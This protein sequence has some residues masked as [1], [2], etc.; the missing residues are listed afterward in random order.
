MTNRIIEIQSRLQEKYGV[1]A[2]PGKER[3]PGGRSMSNGSFDIRYEVPLVPQQ[4]GMSCWAAGAAM[5]VAWR[6]GYSVDPQQIAM[7]TGEWASY[8]D[9]LH[10][11]NASI[12]NVW[13]LA[14]EPQQSYSVTAFGKLLE[15]YGP[16]WVG[17]AAP[18]PHI[19]VVT[20]IYGDSTPDGTYVLVNDPWQK[21]MSTFSL[22]NVGAQY[23]ETYREF[24]L[25]TEGLASKEGAAF[26]RAIY[27]AHSIARRGPRNQSRRLSAEPLGRNQR[28]PF[29]LVTSLR[30]RSFALP[31]SYDAP[32]A[33]PAVQ[34]PSP[35]TSWAAAAAMLVSYKE[36]RT[37][38]AE[39][40][41][42]RAGGRY[43]LML[44][45]D[46][47]MPRSEMGTFL[48]A[49]GLASEPVT[50][51]T[52]EQLHSMLRRFG[53]VWLTP[54]YELA[55][56]PD[57]RIV[58]G[59]HGD[60]TATGTT[61]T[62]RDPHT[63]A[64]MKVK[65]DALL[66]LY[67]HF[68][69]A[70][71]PSRLLAVYWFPDTL[72]EVTPADGATATH[73]QVQQQSQWSRAQNPIA[74]ADAIQM[75]LGAVSV[76]QAQVA[77]SQGAFTLT[78][79]KAQR[80]L[81]TEAR[82]SMPGS[83]VNKQNYRQRLLFLGA[84]GVNLA[85]AQVFIE[86]EGNPYGEI[87]TPIIRRDLSSSTE[88]SRSSAQITI[89]KVDR[90]PLPN[91]DPRTWPVVY[92]YEGTYDPFGNGYFEFSGEFE[93]NAFGSLRF[94]RHEV[95]SRSLLDFAIRGVPEQYV[96]KGNDVIMPIPAIPQE[97]LDYLR[98]KLP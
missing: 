22:P 28:Q 52:V 34:Q 58:T 55:F 79:D 24:V 65:F 71:L 45:N 56:S 64:E 47:T 23:T 92:S 82:A 32:R 14:P 15:M 26:P 66:G 61:A 3:S 70:G 40:A 38:T 68:A 89:T 86:W 19:R 44:R 49:L 87:S 12:F 13:G 90:I 35:N 25:K 21:G 33:V 75:G 69:G 94:T 20:G 5:I 7:G 51:L 60:G 41:V 30:S 77:A 84:G 73:V 59:L 97:Q 17:A 1:K 91:S 67:Q 76:A 85:Y 98:A 81:S 37:V 54:D 10:P 53:V 43:E 96:I 31:V 57:A 74:V 36:G 72:G 93:I 42:R 62:I 78:Y 16:L 9:G 27:V 88:W 48:A 63:G 39:E 6:E 18:G 29:T 4:T 83:Q 95:V 80:L 46:S 11:E 50:D 2:Q 8:T